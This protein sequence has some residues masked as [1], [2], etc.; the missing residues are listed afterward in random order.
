MSDDVEV[1]LEDDKTPKDADETPVEVVDAAEPPSEPEKTPDEGIQE[2]K[3]RFEAERNARYDAEKRA[4]EAESVAQRAKVD[5][6]DANYHMVVNAIETVKGRADAL[7]SAYREAMSVGDFD[8]AAEIQEAIAVN[9][10][11][12]N[13]LRQGEKS[14]KAELEEAKKAPIKPVEPP[15]GDLVDQLV[16]RVS[17]RSADW[18]KSNRDKLNDERSIRRMFRAH[19]DAVDESIEPDS[20]KYFEFIE[21]RLGIRKQQDDAMSVAAKRAD[22][23]PPPAPVSR[24]GSNRPNV[25]RLSREQAEMA[26]MMGMTEADYAKNMLALQKEGKLH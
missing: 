6:T 11:R 26:K 18:L 21:K 4:R 8:K 16:E 13:D 19:E 10:T 1:V 15:R 3:K 24:S 20:D 9:A 23:P 12:L 17:P 2:L 25:V 14:M 5:V 22:P 7:K